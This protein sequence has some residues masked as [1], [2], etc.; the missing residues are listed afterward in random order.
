MSQPEIATREKLSSEW[1]RSCERRLNKLAPRDFPLN[2][3]LLDGGGG[4]LDSSFALPRK[5]LGPM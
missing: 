4:L 3:E 5:L 1:S 2:D